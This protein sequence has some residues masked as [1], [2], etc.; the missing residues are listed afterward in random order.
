MTVHRI[1]ALEDDDLRRLERNL[2][3]L[4]LEMIDIVVPEDVLLAAAM[5]D[6]RDHRGMVLLVGEDHGSR[7]EPGDG[8][9][10]RFV[11]DIGR[12]EEKRGFLAMQVGE[13]GLELDVVVGGAGYVA[14]AAGTGADRVDRLMHCSADHGVLAHAEIV[15]RA[16]HGHLAR[17]M[18]GEVLGGWI[19][20]AAALQIGKDAVAALAMQRF[21]VLAE[22]ILIIHS[23]LPKTAGRQ[24]LCANNVPLLILLPRS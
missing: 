13:L 11:C 2:P 10:G 21:Q 17:A 14:R 4:L 18:P 5:A 12:G 15:V 20:S 19:G 1:D 3:Q 22:A 9:E 23:Y 16:P 24:R 7:N 8:R 6:A